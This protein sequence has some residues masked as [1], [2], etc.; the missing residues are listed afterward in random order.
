MHLIGFFLMGKKGFSVL[1]GIQRFKPEYLPMINFVVCAK[2]S[3]IENDFYDEINN[4]CRKNGID[5]IDK[6]KAKEKDLS[7][8]YAFAISWR[9][10]IHSVTFK[11]IVLHDS[12]IPK[13]RGFNP[14]V[15]AL[16]EG[17]NE[18]GVTALEIG[19]GFDS[20]DIFDQKKIGIQYPIKIKEA[21]DL[22]LDLYVKI[23]IE[24]L[25]KIKASNLVSHKQDETKV[26]YSLWRN[27]EDYKI[28]WSQSSDRLERFVNAVGSPYMGALT[29]YKGLNIRLVDAQAMPD[30]EITNRKAGKILKIDNN[31]PLVV[32][33][34]GLLKINEAKVDINNSTVK[35]DKLRVRLK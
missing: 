7:A 3:A 11:L 2:D 26:T 27:E 6:K 24:L 1:Q 5:F 14:L 30:L 9:W 20:G 32:C 17:D 25:D 13:Y 33:G 29:N 19:N 8:D 4:F 12:L 22:V 28:D 15:T 18:I 31:F 21:I 23:I 16:I 35:F 10:L 34:K